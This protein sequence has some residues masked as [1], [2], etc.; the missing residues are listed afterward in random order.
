MTIL[1]TQTDQLVT[2]TSTISQRLLRTERNASV[3]KRIGT[4]ATKE[5]LWLFRS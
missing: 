4:R 3:S 2:L 1:S 5:R